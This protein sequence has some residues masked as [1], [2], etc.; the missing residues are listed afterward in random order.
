MRR[1]VIPQAI[2]LRG[3]RFRVVVDNGLRARGRVGLCDFGTRTISLAHDL[4]PIEAEE[5]FLHEVLHGLFPDGDA[6]LMDAETEE[7][8]VE[9]LDEPLLRVLRRLEWVG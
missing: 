9:H 6:A 8:V 3:R 7:R 5:A 4:T 2:T 1:L